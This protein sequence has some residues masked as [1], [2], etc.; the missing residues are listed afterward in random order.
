MFR[1]YPWVPFLSRTKP[2]SGSLVR[3]VISRNSLSMF[4]ITGLRRLSGH[5]RKR[6]QS[7]GV[8]ALIIWMALIRLVSIYSTY[9]LGGML[10]SGQARFIFEQMPQKYH[11]LNNNC[12]DYA[13]HL[14]LKLFWS[15]KLLAQLSPYLQIEITAIR[16]GKYGGWGY[17][18]KVLG[19]ISKIHITTTNS[20]RNE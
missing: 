17:Y 20:V 14:F 4:S 5:C 1:G 3:G 16:L 6:L 12:Q 9:T 7:M 8:L 2:I 10:N 15:F 11:L 19:R 18:Y 13:V